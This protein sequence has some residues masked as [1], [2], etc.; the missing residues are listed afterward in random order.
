MKIF[1]ILIVPMV[2]L[3]SLFCGPDEGGGPCLPPELIVKNASGYKINKLYIHD[4]P[5]Y[6]GGDLLAADMLQ[7]A[8]ISV[9]VS[10]GMVKYFTFIRNR[11]SSSSV[12]IAVTT[13]EPVVFS[14]CYK[15]TLNLLPLD[16]FL[17]D[18]GNYEDTD[19]TGAG[20]ER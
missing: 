10:D 17:Q 18:F 4:T 20:T 15:Y 8:E 12:E 2:I 19:D 7:N 3:S 1:S 13:S 5:G 11:T 14:Q 6:S 9:P 16:F